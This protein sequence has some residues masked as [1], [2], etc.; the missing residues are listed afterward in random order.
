MV[1]H[2]PRT[3]G[4]KVGDSALVEGL[5][6]GQSEQHVGV[7]TA[8]FG[9]QH[10][11]EGKYEV[12]GRHRIAIR[13]A[14]L[15]AQLKRVHAPVGG[16]GPAFGHARHG[17]QIHGVFGYQSLQDAGDYVVV[18]HHRYHMRVQ[19]LGIEQVAEMQDL[20]TVARLH[21]RFAAGAAGR[22]RREQSGADELD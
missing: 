7:G 8:Q 2:G 17:V 21:R 18:G 16:H 9:R 12:A 20:F 5:R 4:A 15:G 6:V 11:L 1:V 13:P 14:G 22:G 3:D 10:P 19:I